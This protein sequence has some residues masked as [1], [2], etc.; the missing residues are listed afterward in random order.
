MNFYRDKQ[1]KGF[2]IFLFI[3][4]LLFLGM[5]IVFGMSQINDAKALLLAHDEAV[6][7]SL[8]DRGVSRDVV[9][10]ALTNTEVNEAG[11]NLLAAVGIGKQADNRLL[12]F[13]HQF[14]MSTLYALI[15]GITLLCSILA[16]GTLIFFSKRKQLYEQAGE[17]LTNYIS[18]DYSTHLPQNS[19]GAIYQIYA[20]IEQLATML[21]SQN[22][23]EHKVKE[24]LKS[25]ISD[26]S[27]Q[28]KTPLAAL[29]IYQE[30]IES[31]PDNPETVKEF[32]AKIGDALKRIEQLI[33]SMLKITRL[34]T[35]NIV[36][37]KGHYDITELIALSINE[38]TTRAKSE[39][40]QIWIDGDSKQQ[41]IC[42]LEWTSEAIGNIVKNALDHTTAGGIV[43]I[44]WERTPVMLRIII[45]D[46]GSGIAPEDIHHIFKRFYR[47]KHSIDI[48]GIGL[49]LPLAKSIIEGQRGTLSVRSAPGEGAVFTLSFLTES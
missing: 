6:A 5:G 19:E 35:G 23:A 32:S 16:V 46:N 11:Q 30:I 3:F 42:D 17:I 18:G 13:I 4:A 38:L 44:T 22:E 27:H 7:S 47:S 26:I 10:A 15:I 28:L 25:T 2:S 39:N 21:Q 24:F 9:A 43:H 29:T 49:G 41:I 40:K 34:D 14:Q 20:F 36:F 31:E 33:Q 8:L 37:E 1:I 45:A 48:Q 12:P